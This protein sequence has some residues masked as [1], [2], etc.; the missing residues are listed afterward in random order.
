LKEKKI[1]ASDFLALGLYAFAGFGLE[2]LLSMILPGILNVKSS[3]YTL[4]HQC[5]YWTLTCILWGAVTLFL[6]YLSKTRY[7]FDLMECKGIPDRKGWLGAIIVAASAIGITTAVGEGFKP[8]LEYHGIVRF[9]FQNVYYLFETAL[10]MLTIAFGQKFGELLTKREGLPY[11][12]LFLALTWGLV[13]I[14]IQN[15]QTGIYTVVI[16][17]LYGIVYLLLNKNIRY[18]YILVAIMFIL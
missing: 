14:L 13:H 4:F 15:L 7:S 6:I 1:G 8:V 18:S 10:I 5:I 11:G 2:I 16:S 17:L 9:L 3:D 12:G